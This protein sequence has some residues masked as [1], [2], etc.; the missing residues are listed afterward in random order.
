MSKT[1]AGIGKNNAKD[2]TQKERV[3]WKNMLYRVRDHKAYSDCSVCGR[4]EFLE[5]FL[6]DIRKF[7]NYSKWLANPSD[8]SLDK[9]T[10]IKGNKI[11][12]A[13][14]CCFILKTDNNKYENKPKCIKYNSKM[15]QCRSYRA[16]HKD[17]T[18]LTFNNQKEFAR[19]YGCDYRNVSRSI[20]KG[21][22][23]RGWSIIEIFE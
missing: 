2:Y 16:S 18:I 23:T 5:N 14:Y 15:Y 21:G 13:Q 1:V 10:I 20:N 4:W 3:L 22:K 19:T 7:T 9:D 11:Y 17:G 8:W 6:E 12:G